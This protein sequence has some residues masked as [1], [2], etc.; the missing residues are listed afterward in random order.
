MINITNKLKDWFFSKEDALIPGVF[1]IAFCAIYLHQLIDLYPKLDIVMGPKG[2]FG[3]LDPYFKIDLPVFSLLHTYGEM[4]HINI[5]FFLS[6]VI[7]FLCHWDPD[8]QLITS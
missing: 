2:L 6:L 3:I 8:F 1:R 7:T 4:L 5:W